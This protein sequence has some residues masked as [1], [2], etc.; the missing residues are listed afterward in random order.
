[1][2]VE[3]MRNEIGGL[4]DLAQSSLTAAAKN[5]PVP[6]S[7]YAKVAFWKSVR[8][9]LL[10]AENALCGLWLIERKGDWN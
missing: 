3:Q 6:D 1:M 10:Q 8:N 7:D 4:A 2:T 5:Y 9:G